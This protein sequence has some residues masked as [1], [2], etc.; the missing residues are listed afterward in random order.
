MT[1]HTSDPFATPEPDRSPVRRFRGRLPAPVTLWTATGTDGRRAGLTVSSM[2]VADGDPA[3]LLGV[4]DEESDL[5][6]AVEASG[7]FAVSPLRTEDRQVADRFAGLMPAP[8]GPFTFGR[9]IDTPHGPVLAG[10]SAWAGCRLEASRP[11]GWGLLVE[12]VIEDVHIDEE[13]T[14][15]P[16]VHYRGRYHE[17]AGR[18]LN[19]QPD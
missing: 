15:T 11:I 8:G 3:R 4:L 1:I 12:G 10:L 16:L 2:V 9:W 7:R 18:C 13:R 14:V 19:E 17:L 6:G 5:W